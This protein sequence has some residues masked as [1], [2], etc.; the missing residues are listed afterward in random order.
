MWKI[1][2]CPFDPGRDCTFLQRF[3][4]HDQ[5]DIWNW[6]RLMPHCV[7]PKRHCGSTAGIGRYVFAL[8][9]LR[10]LG[11]TPL[12]QDPLASTLIVP[13]AVQSSSASREKYPSA[14]HG[15]MN[16]IYRTSDWSDPSSSRPRDRTFG[17]PTLLI[18]AIDWLFGAVKISRF[19]SRTSL[20]TS[21]PPSQPVLLRSTGGILCNH[22]LNHRLLRIA[23]FILLPDLLYF[24]GQPTSAQTS[25]LHPIATSVQTGQR[26]PVRQ[27]HY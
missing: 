1:P 22:H 13:A 23:G 8:R 15:T 2:D 4:E 7:P 14:S 16:L 11:Y 24:S 21:Y 17:F 12:A 5:I 27:I 3:T 26:N 20:S 18:A 6:R 25:S 19:P 10:L 9:C